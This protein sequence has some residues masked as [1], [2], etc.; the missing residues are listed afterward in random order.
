MFLLVSSAVYE[1][2]RYVE[3]LA[4]KGSETLVSQ[5]SKSYLPQ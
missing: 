2:V 3:Y 5:G 1:S 4:E